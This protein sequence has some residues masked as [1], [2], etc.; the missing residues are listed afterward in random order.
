MEQ[1]GGDGHSG[2]VGAHG[3]QLRIPLLIPPPLKSASF[4]DHLFIVL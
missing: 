2:Y 4:G 3:G 1:G